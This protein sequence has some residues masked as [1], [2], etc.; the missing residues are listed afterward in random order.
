MGEDRCKENVGN[1]DA[2]CVY[3]GD[4]CFTNINRPSEK[5]RK[6][7]PTLSACTLRACKGCN[8]GD[9]APRQHRAEDWLAHMTTDKQRLY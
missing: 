1:E 2:T 8:G 4:K 3:C 9:D 7:I 5:M 6:R